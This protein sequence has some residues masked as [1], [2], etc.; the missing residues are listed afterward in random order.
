MFC[1][2]DILTKVAD[3]GGHNNA[4]GLRLY[5][6]A[7]SRQSRFGATFGSSAPTITIVSPASDSTISDYTV[8]VTGTFNTSL[9]E[10]GINVNGY[11]ALQDGAEF[12]TFVPLDNQTTSL[13][14][15]VTNTSGT[16]LGS[17]TIPITAQSTDDRTGFVFPAIPS[18]C[19]GIAAGGVYV[20]QSK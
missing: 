16:T 3:S 8:R 5:Y 4:V 14:A 19:L 18:Y 1:R 9:G 17:H 10:V 6:D 2:S 12:A 11:V 15:T 7:A 20:D 13:T